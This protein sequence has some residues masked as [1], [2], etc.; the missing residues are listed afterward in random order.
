LSVARLGSGIPEDKL[1]EIFDP[2]SPARQEASWEWVERGCLVRAF[3]LMASK[4]ST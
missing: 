3:A 1:T 4:S 2:F